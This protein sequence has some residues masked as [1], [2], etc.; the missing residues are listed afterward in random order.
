MQLKIYPLERLVNSLRV[1]GPLLTPQQ[2]VNTAIALSDMCPYDFL[3]P[4]AQG[5]LIVAPSLVG[6]E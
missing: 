3:D 1:H 6:V 2:N 4:F 5:S